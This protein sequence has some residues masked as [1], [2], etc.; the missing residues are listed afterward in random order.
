MF[1]ATFE[2][3]ES[4]VAKNIERIARRILSSDSERERAGAGAGATSGTLRLEEEQTHY[5]ILETEPGVSDEEA[6]RAYRTLKEIYAAGSP[7]IA[8]L[9]HDHQLGELHS[10]A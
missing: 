6:R 7:V 4:K 9:D 8:G 2:Y 3:P 5:E 10:P 1:L